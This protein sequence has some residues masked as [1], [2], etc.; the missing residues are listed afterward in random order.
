MRAVRI[1]VYKMTHT[2]DPDPATGIWGR[3]GCMGQVRGYQYDAVIGIGGVS[4]IDGIAG[5]VA[6]IGVGPHRNGSRIMPVVTFDR[7]VFGGSQGDLLHRKAPALARHMYGGRVRVLL[8][9]SPSEHREAE[10][11]LAMAVAARKP[12]IAKR[13]SPPC[14]PRIKPRCPR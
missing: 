2:G 5:R 1:L 13:K 9:L 4:A 11:L 10:R 3:T 14:P 7:F 12:A 6:W 8:N